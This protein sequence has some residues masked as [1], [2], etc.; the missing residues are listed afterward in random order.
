MTTFTYNTTHKIL[1]IHVK[2]ENI[3]LFKNKVTADRQSAGVKKR[4]RYNVTSGD[5]GAAS[6]GTFDKLLHKKLN[7]SD[8]VA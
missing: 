2:Q 4:G 8:G 3:S 7:K 5:G 6:C 1:N